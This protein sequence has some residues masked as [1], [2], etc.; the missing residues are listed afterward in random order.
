MDNAWGIPFIGADIRK[1]GSDIIIYSM[2]KASGAPTSGLIIGKEEP[3]VQI[4]RALGIHGARYGTTSSHGKAAYVGFDPGKEALAGTLAAL[5]VLKDRP[6]IQNE[7]LDGLYNITMEEFQN[8]PKELKEGWAICKSPNS[9]AVE[10]NYQDSWKNGQMGIPIFSIE[11]MYAGSHV[12]Q[13]CMTQMGMAATIA[14][15]GNIFI[16]NGTGNVDA[17]GK[18]DVKV[19]RIMVKALFE[20][21]KIISR[22]AGLID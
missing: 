8:L 2:D 5:K 19:T 17:Q 20:M 16:S 21:I 4:R 10:L 7:M 9:G 12:L 15:D 18:L 3:M 6:N 1:I 11:D 14:Y 22:Y 13:N